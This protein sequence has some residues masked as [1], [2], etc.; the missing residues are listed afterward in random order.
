MV[1]TTTLNKIFL[2]LFSFILIAV[3]KIN[4]QTTTVPYTASGTWLCPAGVTSIKFEAYGAGGGG[5]GG[6][7]SNKFGGGGGGGGGYAVHTTVPVTPGT[8]YTITVGT[9]GTAGAAGA[10]GGN[11]NLSRGV[12]G[13]LTITATG[14]AGGAGYSGAT[15]PGGVGG[16]GSNG[17]TNST[18]GT[19]GA[20][21]NGTG[22]GGGG[23]CAGT[24]G[25]GGN[26]S[27]PTGG[28]AGGGTIAGDGGDGSTA[29]SNSGN[30]GT[31][32]GGGGSGGTKSVSGSAGAPGYVLIT[33]T[34]PPPPGSTCA[35]AVDI[36]CASGTISGS[37]VG[38]TN[39]PHGTGCASVNNYGVW[40]TFDGDG[41]S[42]TI[43][44]NPLFDIKLAVA[45]GAC[46]ALTNI[47][48]TDASPET[49]TFNTVVG[50]TYYVYV[51]GYG[52]GSTTGTFTIARTCC[53][54]PTTSNAGP[55]QTLANCV[56]TATLAANTPTVG[57]GT[58]TCQSGCTGVTI[59]NPASPTTTVTGL[60]SGTSTFRWRITNGTCS[61]SNDNV[62][63]IAACPPS[64]NT[65]ATAAALP[66]GSG[67]INGTTVGTTSIVHGTGC[68]SVNNYGVWYTFVGNGQMTTITTN[69]SFDI[70]LSVSTGSCGS[71]TNIVCTDSSP[72][73]ATFTTVSGTTYY[74]YVAGY[75][76]G[77]T[78]GTFTI[79]RTCCS[80]PTVPTAGSDI[81]NACSTTAT[82]AGNAAT[83]GT[84]TWTVVSGPGSVTT[85]SAFN[86]G[87]TG[88]SAGTSTTFRW[89][90]SNACATAYDDVIVANICGGPANQVCSG[91]VNLPCGTTSLAGTTVG[92]S[93]IANSQGCSMSSYGVWYSFVGD[94]NKNSITVTPGGTFDSE[95]S[96]SSGSCGSFT[97]ITCKDNSGAES[98]TFTATA[99]VTYYVYVAHYSSGSTTT[100]A[101]T[102][103]R[104]C[105]TCPAG[106]GAGNVS[107]ASLPYS[108]A[109][110]TTVGAG[111]DLTDT[112]LPTCGSTSY[113]TGA[114]KVYTFTPTSSGNIT[115]TLNSGS[116]GTSIKL[117][118][119]CPFTGT[120]V[121]YDEDYTSG[122]KTFCTNVTSGQ[123]YYLIVDSYDYY[124]A[125]IGS[126][127]ID[128]TAPTGGAPNDLPCNATTIFNGT[129]VLGNNE[130]TSATSETG[131]PSC[132]TSGPINSVW[133]KFQATSTSMYLQTTLSTIASTQIA[134]YSGTCG[135]LTY[136]LCNQNA[137]STGCAGSVQSNSLL[138]M[139][140]L[141]VG[142]WYWV[143]V[144]G[145]D[146][147]QG[148][149]NIIL[150]DGTSVTTNDPILGQDC[151]SPVPIC[152]NVVTVP[153]PSYAGT[154]NI[155]DFT[156][157]N[158]CTSGEKNSVWYTFEIGAT[159]N[160]NFTIYPNDATN[161]SNGAE[162]DY[163]WVLWKVSNANGTPNASCTTLNAGAP[164]SCNYGS[165]G[166]TGIAPGGNAPSPINTYFNSTF[167]PTL[168]VTAG[169]IYVLVV[170]N[171]ETTASGFELDFST[172]SPGTID[173]SPTTIFW[174]GA[175]N[176]SFTNVANY[177]SCS[178]APACGINVVINNQGFQPTISGTT[179]YCRDLTIN[180]GATLTFAA[181]STLYICGSLTNNG[182]IICPTSST[183]VFVDGSNTTQ[184]VTGNFTGTTTNC[185]GNL[186][187]TKAAGSVILNS[188]INIGGNFLT[189]NNTSVFNSNNKYV[190]LAGHF[191]NANGN[192]T[193]TTTGTLG[194]LDFIGAGLQNYNQ[195]SSQLD[196]NFVKV[197]NTASATA[198]VTLLTDM[199]VKAT[200][201]TL[202]LTTGTI[203][204]GGT[205]NTSSSATI[206]GG[207]KVHVW[208]TTA[209]S[210]NT[211]STT[212]YVNGT[213]RRYLGA[214]G[215]YDWP[216]GKA[217]TVGY[218]RANTTFS[219]TSG[220]TYVDSRFDTW[221][222]PCT[223]NT[224]ECSVS[225]TDPSLNNGMWTFLPSGGTCTYDCTL[226]PLNATNVTG[227]SFTIIKR[228]HTTAIDNTGW[229]LDGTCVASPITAV[230][231]NGMANFSFMGVD[232]GPVT[233]PIELISF[234]GHKAGSANVLEWVTASE[235][236]N[237][238]FTL[239][240][241]NSGS[242]FVF[243]SEID[244]AGNSTTNKYYTQTDQNIS[245]QMTYYRLKQTDFNGESTYSKTIALANEMEDIS[246]SELFPNPSN[247]LTS[248]EIFTPMTEVVSIKLI[249]NSGRIIY[250]QTE[251]I[252]SGKHTI[253]L[254]LEKYARGAYSLEINLDN[255]QT[256]KV[257]KLIKN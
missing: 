223:I 142:T 225:Y 77:S 83:V 107:V 236:D 24:T 17:T 114:D 94:G 221:P 134:L 204:T 38:T 90:I 11:G 82:L 151:A 139:T 232:Q 145:R 171:F 185:F 245:G 140:T 63:I 34:T 137:G 37:T 1:R 110:H 163:D 123:T 31:N 150:N 248:F 97:N 35:G 65:C 36:A 101:F 131:T 30:A 247:Q 29:N 159:G 149:F 211:G 178:V 10:T 108:A 256:K 4:A 74:V 56:T 116:D 100:G 128:I 160:L 226:Y 242:D 52:S 106:L 180:S 50:T 117:Y 112:N 135:A 202:T 249:D 26:G 152:T 79:S 207:F 67:T 66:C 136:L 118:Q 156:G 33:Y 58:W 228:P 184:T 176:T 190:K 161:S 73:T 229:I 45:T 165:P 59:T 155:C 62:D 199:H 44:T 147:N 144:D 239:E 220:M 153:N 219:T 51:A 169:E 214:S 172:S 143:R 103:S 2:I 218:Q 125:D 19:G 246:I 42:T 240:K 158:N 89:T 124:S 148:A 217:S 43:T 233:L 192:S 197:N 3:F 138:D 18:G 187:V 254:D 53:T 234:E 5:G 80:P 41:Q 194:T 241:S 96:I 200:T 7:G 88:I 224:N 191:T 105:L 251:T 203:T 129:S 99:G 6:G 92:T 182:T 55:D 181:N 22:S 132:W 230:R 12:F 154:G 212:S 175:A 210:V 183:I 237:D 102:I 141:T 179:T 170:Q 243:V 54:P 157:T 61:P 84:G 201:G 195:G 174:N 189:S 76:S 257:Q 252:K 133:Y 87:V 121:A 196:L 57:T 162:T 130:C 253:N 28:T 227:A 188:N 119:G 64:N 21:T 146:D 48:C 14:G 98:H 23:G 86:S 205:L 198:G 15:N 93:N 122:V 70:K 69:P 39:I 206:T 20:G 81:T 115:V 235:R 109:G 209:A 16:T 27:M 75:G 13:G 173:A 111:D 9:A 104:Q 32:Y 47:V 244:G 72:E 166:I 208:N 177:G 168:A 46:G 193:Y 78:T 25:N 222:T 186:T 164:T 238:Y 68:G 126:Y 120:C 60:S 167:E 215:S 231:R 255:S 113:S 8:T 127:T 40:Y 95:L 250:T 71:L 216:V 91:A 49:A 213:L 85:P